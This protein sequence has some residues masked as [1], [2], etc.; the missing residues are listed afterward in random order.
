[1]GVVPLQLPPGATAASLALDGGETFDVTGLSVGV[2]PG[3]DVTLTIHRPGAAAQTLA[4]ICR[5]DTS[6]EAEWL[7]H[8]GILPNALRTLA[9]EAVLA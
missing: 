1:M 3:M 4:L 9:A 7:R 6:V 5:V 2:S 8:G